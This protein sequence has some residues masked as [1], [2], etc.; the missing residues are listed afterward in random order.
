MKL[1]YY[2]RGLGIGIVVTAI[3]MSFTRQ[4]EKLTDAQIKLRAH[5]L[6]MVERNVLS[7]YQEELAA[8][9]ENLDDNSITE[10][11]DSL[12]EDNE[13]K[14]ESDSTDSNTDEKKEGNSIEENSKENNPTEG[15][16]VENSSM[17]EKA[18]ELVSSEDENPSSVD[19]VGNEEKSQSNTNIS[20]STDGSPGNAVNVIQTPVSTENNTGNIV[21]NSTVDNRNNSPENETVESYVVVYLESGYGSEYASGKVYEAGLVTSATELNQYLIRNGLDRNLKAGNHEIP[22]GAT[23]EEIARILCRME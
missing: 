19:S 20:E 22:V 4:P 15:N 3:I 17:E 8:N 14:K 21:N 1:K 18:E 9:N 23:I 7:D 13:G 10:K 6:G 2:L 12:E 16:D 11:A 5:E